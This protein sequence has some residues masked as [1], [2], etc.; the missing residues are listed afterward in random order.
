M[1]GRAESATG[2]LGKAI[3]VDYTTRDVVFEATIVPPD[4][5]FGIVFHRVERLP[6][7]PPD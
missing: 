5:P 1:P 7:Y 6:L 2:P 4:A 3:E